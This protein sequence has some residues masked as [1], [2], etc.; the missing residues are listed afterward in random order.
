[1]TSAISFQKKST[2]TPP[3]PGPLPSDPTQFFKLIFHAPGGSPG[4]IPEFAHLN[5]TII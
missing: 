4:T 1:M 5:H 2:E 3:P